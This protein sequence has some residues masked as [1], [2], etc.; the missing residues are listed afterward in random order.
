VSQASKLGEMYV[1]LAKE[2]YKPVE[3]AL[4]KKV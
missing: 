1:T 4:A 2:A 3:K